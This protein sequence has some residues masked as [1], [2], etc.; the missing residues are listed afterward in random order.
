MKIY[1]GAL[2]A[3]LLWIGQTSAANYFYVAD[4]N[5]GKVIKITDE[6]K[7]LWDAP[8]GNGHDVQL[9]PNKNLLI[10]HG[11][12]VEEIDPDRKVVW[13]VGSPVVKSAE[14]AQRL[15]SGNTVIA[16]NGRMK[17][18]EIDKDSKVVWEFDVPNTNKRKTPTMRQVRRLDNGNTL[19][20]ASTEDKVIEVS[21]DKKVVWSYDVP[22]PYLATRLPD[23]NTLISSGDGYGSPRGWFVIEV[24]KAGKTVW[25]YGGDDAPEDQKL[26]FP[27]GHVRLANGNTFI[28]DANGATIR[29]VAP[30]KRTL[31]LITSPAMKHPA[32][33]VYVQEEAPKVTEVPEQRHKKN[34]PK[35]GWDKRA[36]GLGGKLSS[37]GEENLL[38]LKGDR[39]NKE[40][41]LIHEFNHAI[42]Q[43]GLKEVDPTFDPRLREVFNKAMEKGLWKGTYLTTNHSEYWAEGAQAYFDCMRPQ[44]GANT[45][46]KLKDYDIDLFNLVDEVYKQ[47]PYRYVRYDKRNPAKLQLQR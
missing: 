24:D 11:N 43:Q 20:S 18:I 34:D 33:I 30:D 31:R 1:L 6:G 45:R 19:I 27:S 26:H 44:Y 41:I 10:V 13:K 9:L 39:Y 23:G 40:N 35:T 22:F 36:R 12:W 7:L 3:F 8:N 28:A 29:E 46:E 25:K 15:P 16:D 38:N 5:T 2:A 17:V 14:S 4:H 21:P 37:C 32:T 47:S 42:H